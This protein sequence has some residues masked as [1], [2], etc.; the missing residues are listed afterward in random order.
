MWIRRGSTIS[1]CEIAGYIGVTT[2][3]GEGD[4]PACQSGLSEGRPGLDPRVGEGVNPARIL[5]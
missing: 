4:C 2:R 3:K 1:A 5:P